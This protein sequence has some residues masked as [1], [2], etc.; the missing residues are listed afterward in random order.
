MGKMLR[1]IKTILLN[2]LFEP[3]IQFGGGSIVFWDD[4]NLGGKAI[5]NHATNAFDGAW[6]KNLTIASAKIADGAIG[7]AKIADLAVT[8]AK[9]ADGAVSAAKIATGAVGTA[10]LADGGVT[11]VKLAADV[12][13][14]VHNAPAAVTV[15][16][17]TYTLKT[18][19]A[20]TRKGIIPLR[21]VME[22]T[23]P[24]GSGVTQNIEL[25]VFDGTTEYT[26]HTVTGIAEGTSVSL[27]LLMPYIYSKV[28][29]SVK[30]TEIRLYSLVSATPAAGYE[31]T[32]RH[33]A[34]L[35]DF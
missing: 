30:I 7:T 19:Y 2:K 16:E 35:Y 33:V 8:L 23:N 28:A 12:Y 27:E 10:Q 20:A 11:N 6:I 14:I 9:I 13:G 24:T 22:A 25:R 4:I 15:T 5:L 29:A 1:R 34:D 31:P 32:C 21:V 18:S 17:T 26:V 3:Y